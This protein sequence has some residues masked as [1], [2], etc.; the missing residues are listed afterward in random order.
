MDTKCNLSIQ[1]LMMLKKYFSTILMG[2]FLL[3]CEK[4]IT[5]PLDENQSMLVIDA[6]VTDEAGP[7]YVKLTKSVAVS[8][9]SKFPEVSNALVIMKDNFGLSDTL[10]YSNKGLYLTHKIKGAY[11]NTYFLEVM[12][13]G[14]KYTAQSTMPNKVPFD[15]LTINFLTFFNE[16]RYSV[17]PM[18][19]DPIALGNNYRFIQTINDTLDK[20]YHIFNDN[21]NNGKENQRPLNID[22][23]SLQV[24]LNDFVSVEMQCISSPT[25]LY[26]YSLRQISGAGAGGGTTPSNPPSNIMG[27]ALGLFSAHTVQRKKIQIK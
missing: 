26:Y 15:S 14:K 9:V 1:I 6:V 16:A 17:I 12:L 3:G 7:Y 11:G 25:Y 4:E 2:I 22:S 5:L 18:Y 10:K 20:T 21:L 23:D 8:D 24:K 27:G 13:D 19:T